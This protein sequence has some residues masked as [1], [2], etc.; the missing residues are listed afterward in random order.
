[1]SSPSESGAGDC[2]HAAN[3][4]S[5]QPSILVKARRTTLPRQREGLIISV[6]IRNSPRLPPLPIFPVYG[7]MLLA[8]G[9]S[10]ESQSILGS[11]SQIT[12]IL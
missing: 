11:D 10:A 9:R 2:F 4:C 8:H 1:M 7:T 12:R 3:S 6:I 5:A